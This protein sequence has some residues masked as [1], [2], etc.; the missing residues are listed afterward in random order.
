MSVNDFN[1]GNDCVKRSL[2]AY[3]KHDQKPDPH[4]LFNLEYIYDAAFLFKKHKVDS[5]CELFK[6]GYDAVSYIKPRFE[7]IRQEV[8][9]F[10]YFIESCE[11]HHTYDGV[12]RVCDD[13]EEEMEYNNK[14]YYDLYIINFDENINKRNWNNFSHLTSDEEVD[15]V[16]RLDIINFVIGKLA[17]DTLDIQKNLITSFSCLRKN[18]KVKLLSFD[19]YKQDKEYCSQKDYCTYFFSNYN[20]KKIYNLKLL[21]KRLDCSKLISLIE[22]GY[23][24]F[25]YLNRLENKIIEPY[26]EYLEYLHEIERYFYSQLDEMYKIYKANF[27]SRCIDFKDFYEYDDKNEQEEYMQRFY[28]SLTKE[29]QEEFDKDQMGYYDRDYEDDRFST[30]PFDGGLYYGGCYIG[31]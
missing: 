23:D 1:F 6:L 7:E 19:E 31:T 16:V 30:S 28:S 18:E 8:K 21:L 17:G 14:F 25:D 12:I 13:F 29:E 20:L 15:D 4:R 26:H 11:F 9:H 10:E 3:R 24:V 2:I 27:S 22:K 5:F